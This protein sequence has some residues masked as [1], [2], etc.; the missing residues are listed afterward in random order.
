MATLVNQVARD[1]NTPLQLGAVVGVIT[2]SSYIHLGGFGVK[3]LDLAFGLRYSHNPRG[4]IKTCDINDLKKLT[5][6]WFEFIK[7]IGL[8]F[9]LECFILKNEPD[10]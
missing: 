4:A 9:I 5:E 6:F 2:E 8:D 3:W 7:K 1:N 10:Y